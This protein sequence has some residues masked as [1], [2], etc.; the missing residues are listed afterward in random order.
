MTLY[1]KKVKSARQKIVEAAYELSDKNMPTLT[2]IVETL[3]EAAHEVGSNT[4]LGSLPEPIILQ[5]VSNFLSDQNIKWATVGGIAFAAHGYSR[6]TDDVDVLVESLPDNSIIRNKE[7]MSKFQFY[8]GK[9]HGGKHLV[10]D[11]KKGQVEF[12]LAD[13][14]LRIAALSTAKTRSI[15][16][17]NIPVIS[18]E[19]LIGMKLQSLIDN[20]KRESKD[21][22][23]IVYAMIK[24]KNVGWLIKNLSQLEKNVLNTIV[25]NW[26][27]EN[28]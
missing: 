2:S 10:L 6:G 5:D 16:K 17:S 13:N 21:K 14:S 3:L 27:V 15:I 11:H 25:P 4:L 9:S 7:Y 12:L 1:T 28:P 18:L 26:Q 23:A 19:A 20:P 24:I 8:A 22:P